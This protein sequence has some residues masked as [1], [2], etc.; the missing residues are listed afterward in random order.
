M[1]TLGEHP[2][3][4]H[5]GHAAA[6]DED[7][8]AR[9]VRG[10]R[11]GT[12]CLTPGQRVDGAA[13]RRVLL[14]PPHAALLAGDA[15]P[16]QL[17]APPLE[18]VDDLGVRQRG[19]GQRDHLGGAVRHRGRRQV[20]VVHASGHDERDLGARLLELTGPGQV[21]ALGL[22]HRRVRPVPGVVGAHVHVQHL[23]AVGVEQ[24]GRLDALVDV[25]ALLLEL[26][27]GHGAH[28][29][30]L[31]HRLGGEA[32]LD[33]EVLARARVDR[34]DDLAGEAEP[35]LQRP[36]VLVGPV[37]EQGDRELV[38]QVAL[39]DGMDLDPVETGLPGHR[40]GDAELGDDAVDLLHGHLP[41]G[42]ARVPPVGDGRGRHRALAG[43]D[44]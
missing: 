15:G 28:P 4:L 2:G 9:T 42:D 1:A 21:E 39:V 14:D 37:V 33:G 18:L 7:P 25:A 34:V 35:V 19:T 26:L 20:R 38:Q 31:D 29:Q 5:P 40:P 6:H 22:V 16:H 36:A 44:Q 23:V 24:P 30:V 12:L 32:Q 41:A 13:Q 8:Q 11:H 43:S 27:T 17:R 10:L 3:R